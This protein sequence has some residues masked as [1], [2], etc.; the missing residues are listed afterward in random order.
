MKINVIQ[1]SLLISLTVM[2]ACSSD[3]DEDI[4]NYERA[5]DF[6]VA[7]PNPP[8]TASTTTATINNFTVYAFTANKE[9][10]SNVKVNRNGSKWIY[11]PVVYWPA[12]PVNF[13][14]YSPDISSSVD[15]D[16]TG[17]TDI[18]NYTNTGNT[19]LLYA[20]NMNETAKSA[21]VVINFRH[22]LSR[23]AVMLSSTNTAIAVKVHYVMY[24]DIYQRASFTYPRETTSASAIDVVGAWSDFA[25]LGNV[26]SFAIIDNAD[27]VTLDATPVDLTE[28]LLDQSFFIPQPLSE[29]SLE[30][31][32]YVGSSIEVDCE[33]F[34]TASG[35]RIWPTSTTPPSQLVAHST[36]GRLM[37][38]LTTATLKEWKPG[39][40]YI[41]NIKIDNPEELETIDFN[42]T[43]DDYLLEEQ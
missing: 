14:A 26:L 30:G 3:N 16:D 36:T 20:V 4:N 17:L 31:N 39:H 24:N 35:A 28:G 12:T 6:S 40:A 27:I 29:L 18:P 11:T 25:L 33:I 37:F 1:I 19:D 23:V 15:A 2:S 7:V 21:P 8:R 43:V 5:I 32:Q 38:P 34:D 10:M 41:Y 42:V 9:Y 22:A 13:F